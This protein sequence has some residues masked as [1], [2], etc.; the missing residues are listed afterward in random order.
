MLE[1]IGQRA[2]V[3]CAAFASLAIFTTPSARGGVP[4]GEAIQEV[5]SFDGQVGPG[6]PTLHELIVDGWRFS[7]AQFH[8]VSAP[9]AG[10]LVFVDSGSPFIASVG[11]GFDFPI[12]LERVD[13]LPFTLRGFDAAEGFAD[14][15][16]ALLEGFSSATRIRIDGVLDDGG[17]VSF[18][19]ELDGVK[20]GPGGLADF[21]SYGLS[22]DFRQLASVTF[23]G[24]GNGGD[25][26]AAFA[27]DT[28]TVAYVPEPTTLASMIAVACFL[29]LQSWK[30]R[31]TIVPVRSIG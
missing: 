31:H 24:L 8:S 2:V 18:T 22:T 17:T 4:P 10:S 3:A 9:G 30:H 14:D 20:D 7:S 13:G 27:V 26:T 12:T 19:H 1:F 28:L 11:G 15:A 6:N 23:T 21:A 5:I 29:L 25:E 16:A